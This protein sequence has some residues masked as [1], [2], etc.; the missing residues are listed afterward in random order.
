MAPFQIASG[1][2]SP[3]NGPVP[4]FARTR[5]TLQLGR[6]HQ[7]A[8]PSPQSPEF[9]RGHLNARAPYLRPS[10]CRQSSQVAR[11]LCGFDCLR[12]AASTSTVSWK[13]QTDFPSIERFLAGWPT[14]G[15]VELTPKRW[16]ARRWKVSDQS[17]LDDLRITVDPIQV[18]NFIQ[19]AGWSSSVPGRRAKRNWSASST[20]CARVHT[21]GRSKPISQA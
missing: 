12:A 9:S 16:R 11:L 20:A 4:G 13:E 6:A 15:K 1:P 19:T 5:G 8:Q 7:P 3:H 10:R 14:L 17:P 2:A 18:S 21:L